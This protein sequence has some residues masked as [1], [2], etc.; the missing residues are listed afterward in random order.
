MDLKEFTLAEVE[1]AITA[2]RQMLMPPGKEKYFPG[3]DKLRGLVFEARKHRAEL[4]RLGP[5]VPTGNRRPHLWFML[6]KTLWHQ[7][8]RENDVPPGEM[9][10]DATG[11]PMRL[12]ERVG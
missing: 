10:K 12:P 6:P 2:Y 9:I 7:D 8:W 4:E 5:P 11:G 1:N 3:S